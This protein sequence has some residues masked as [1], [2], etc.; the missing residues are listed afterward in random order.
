MSNQKAYAQLWVSC[1]VYNPE[2][3]EY[4]NC[5]DLTLK[6]AVCETQKEL[7]YKLM[8][9]CHIWPDGPDGEDPD[10]VSIVEFAKK[11]GVPE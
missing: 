7:Y 6:L 4:E 5:P 1:E 2:S 10:V 8:S 11:K 3:D 9:S